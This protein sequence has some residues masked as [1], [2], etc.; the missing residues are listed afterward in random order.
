MSHECGYTG[1]TVHSVRPTP[2][3]LPSDSTPPTGAPGQPQRRPLRQRHQRARRAGRRQLW[4]RPLVVCGDSHWQPNHRVRDAITR[5]C[6]RYEGGGL[7]RNVHLVHH[8]SALH[9]VHDGVFISPEL[10]PDAKVGLL[11]LASSKYMR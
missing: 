8:T 11:A 7:Y 4:Q 5:V 9:F 2:T 6:V 3:P 1:F 10:A